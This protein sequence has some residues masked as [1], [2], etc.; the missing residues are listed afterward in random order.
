MR[1]SDLPTELLLLLARHLHNIED[2]VTL[3]SSCRK[4]HKVL[5]S[6]S[7]NTI[8]HLAAASA[9]VFFRPSPHFLVAATARQIGHWALQSDA[10]YNDLREAFRGGMNS[11]L[12]LCVSKAGLTMTDIRRLHSCR[13][14]IINPA[15]DM[16]D[17]CA[18][19]QWYDVPD[20]WNGGRS[21]A[22]TINVEPD[23]SLFQIII[24][25]E[26]F[27]STMDAI[28]TCDAS[29]RRFDLDMR[30]DYIKYCIPD[31]S[32]WCGYVG[33][34][35]GN[36]ALEVLPVGPYTPCRR[37]D[38]MTPTEIEALTEPQLSDFSRFSYSQGLTD[39]QVGLNHILGC[40][41][42]R[43]AWE[44]VRLSFGPDFEEDW[45]QDLWHAAVQQQG[46]DGLELLRPGGVEKWRS[47]LQ[48]V[49]DS[50][51]AMPA[52]SK[53]EIY[54]Y[55]IRGSEASDAPDMTAEILICMTG[56]WGT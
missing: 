46:L 48:R 6:T 51:Q 13:F 33:S 56:F 38:S 36:R 55:G 43:E 15:S 5:N 11:L 4:F 25:G 24:Y 37:I 2:F 29:R 40:R 16:I 41:T 39:D 9:S 3:S 54:R 31:Y 53:P 8:L 50:I 47:R 45:R 21:D 35:D 22:F 49:R 27:S 26:L 28:V 10:N 34:P 19:K 12:E 30:L 17:R 18:G 44:G 1:V 23:R 52:Q 7:P 14:S 42:W 32:C 20:F